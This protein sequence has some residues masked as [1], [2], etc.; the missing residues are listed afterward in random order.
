MFFYLAVLGYDP[1][2]GAVSKRKLSGIIEQL[3]TAG[4]ASIYLR[5]WKKYRTMQRSG[6]GFTIMNALIKPMAASRH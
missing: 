5:H 3:G 2:K 4:S 6:S 1:Q